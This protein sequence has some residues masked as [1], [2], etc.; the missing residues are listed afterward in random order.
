M[1]W[2]RFRNSGIM[3]K[4]IGGDWVD[5]VAGIIGAPGPAVRLLISILLAYPFATFHR[6]FLHAKSP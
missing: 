1:N 6:L 2:N 5:G 4:A 3:S